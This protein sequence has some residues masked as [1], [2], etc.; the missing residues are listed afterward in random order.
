MKR[1][2]RGEAS[3]RPAAFPHITRDW[4]TAG[5]MRDVWIALVPTVLGAIWLH[6]IAAVYLLALAVV[7][8]VGAEA[9]FQLA[10]RRPQTIGDGSAVVTGLI[11]ALTLPT[12]TPPVAIL[13]GAAGAIWLVKL[14]GGGLGKNLLN[15]ALAGRLLISLLWGATLDAAQ[16]PLSGSWVDCILSGGNGPGVP[17]GAVPAALV[18]VGALYLYLRRIITGAASLSFLLLA[19]AAYWTFGA[20]PL[21]TAPAACFAS[22]GFL[23]LT[24]FFIVTDPVTTPATRAGR[25]IAGAMAGTLG[26]ALYL[27]GGRTDGFLAAILIVNVFA[28]WIERCTWPRPRGIGGIRH[29]QQE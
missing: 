28:P 3:V 5:V 2:A 16:S 20:T 15:P 17:I 27:T 8:C 13:A 4:Q 18:L 23:M 19:T 14:F 29:A 9:L 12:A 21:W 24:A 25:V 22:D 11:L 10:R 6:G 1:L 7:T 26:A